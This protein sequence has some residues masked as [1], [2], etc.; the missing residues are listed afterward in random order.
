MNGLRNI[1]IYMKVWH[2]TF[3]PFE[4]SEW[5]MIKSEYI[6]FFKNY[7]FKSC[8]CSSYMSV[9]SFLCLKLVFHGAGYRPESWGP[10]GRVT[11][12]V[13]A[14]DTHSGLVGLLA[15]PP[16][17]LTSHCLLALITMALSASMV[18]SSMTLDR[19]YMLYSLCICTRVM[20]SKL[21]KFDVGMIMC[22]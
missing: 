19:V 22:I 20:K 12:W 3:F 5:R 18:H 17:L 7:Y 16:T 9:F 2:V 14:W 10:V 11:G 21:V 4:W 15:R 8:L 6:G 1:R 13:S